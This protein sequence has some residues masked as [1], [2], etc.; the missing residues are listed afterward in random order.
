MV[1]KPCL[2]LIIVNESLILFNM[3]NNII[4]I[5]CFLTLWQSNIL[6]AQTNNYPSD[7][8]GD[9]I[10]MHAKMKLVGNNVYTNYAASGS[11]YAQTGNNTT[12]GNLFDLSL[13]NKPFLYTVIDNRYKLTDPTVLQNSP[14]IWS[15][16]DPT[17][18]AVTTF[19]MGKSLVNIDNLNLN[20]VDTNISKTVNFTFPH[21]EISADSIVYYLTVGGIKIS[22]KATG[23]A[24]SVTF[25]PSELATLPQGTDA[26][27]MMLIYNVTASTIN[28]RKYYFQ[29]VSMAT[30]SPLVIN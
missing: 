20:L 13:N 26:I 18:Q 15:F 9:L 22:K 11:L 17:S 23:F 6:F 25:S 21:G 3:I 30:V 10:A 4:R 16:T 29:N 8:D 27:F 28:N 19:T 5:L 24:S 12:G 2:K 14:L 7:T 1:D